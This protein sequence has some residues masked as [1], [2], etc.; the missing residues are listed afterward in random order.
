MFE[1][2]ELL[3]SAATVMFV[4]AALSWGSLV[5][6]LVSAKSYS[7]QH[8]VAMLVFTLLLTS[9]WGGLLLI[10]NRSNFDDN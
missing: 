1:P 9:I 5:W 8:W 6:V 3:K 2:E 10:L 7:A 4:A